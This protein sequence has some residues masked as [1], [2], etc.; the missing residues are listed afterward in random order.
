M[1]MLPGFHQNEKCGCMLLKKCVF[2]SFFFFLNYFEHWEMKSVRFNLGKTK[3]SRVFSWGEI[4][5]GFF[6]FKKKTCWFFGFFFLQ[7]ICTVFS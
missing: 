5:A 7:N 2:V 1:R 3:S 4:F 6:F